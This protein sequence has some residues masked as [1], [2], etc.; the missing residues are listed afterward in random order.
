MPIFIE[1]FD[2]GAIF[3]FRDFQKGSFGTPFPTKRPAKEHESEVRVAGLRLVGGD[4]GPIWGRTACP[5]FTNWF[6]R[7]NY[8]ADGRISHTIL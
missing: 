1:I 4:Y 6:L 3:D 5:S 8:A 2:L 7:R